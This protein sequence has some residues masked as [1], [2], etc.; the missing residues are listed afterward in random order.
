MPQASRDAGMLLFC[1]MMERNLANRATHPLREGAN[2]NPERKQFAYVK[3]LTVR[4]RE[5]S[6]GLRIE[7][8][9]KSFWARRWKASWCGALTPGR[10]PCNSSLF[11][12]R[13]RIK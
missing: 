12:F 13:P 3:E 6:K 4:V 1:D 9:G 2:F 8:P 7:D 10:S 5:A 11:K